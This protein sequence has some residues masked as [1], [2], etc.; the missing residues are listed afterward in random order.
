MDGINWQG[1]QPRNIFNDV[2]QG[3][4]YG[5]DLRDRRQKS[6]AAAARQR[7]MNIFASD[8]AAAERELMALG[9]IETANQ[10]RTRAREDRTDKAR[11]DATAMYGKG[12]VEGAQRTAIAAG[13]FDLAKEISGLDATKRKA[14]KENAEEIGGFAQAI[15]NVPYEQRKAILQQAAPI[16]QQK[17]FTPEQIAGFDP[18]DEALRGLVASA[19]DLKTALDEQDRGR[20]NA[21]ADAQLEETRRS[22]RTREGISRGQL[23]VAQSNSARGWAAHKARAAAGGY[24]TPGVGSADIPDDEVEID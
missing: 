5:S 23:G 21:R 22:N 2:A 8:P 24:G 7:A 17:G 3:F 1:L 10:L 20:D 11:S 15:A 18:T 12:D 13:D 16:L 14:A 19:M 6:E 9:D 4:E